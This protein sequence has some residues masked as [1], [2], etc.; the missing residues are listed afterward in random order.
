[1]RFPISIYGFCGA[2]LKRN[3]KRGNQ[4]ENCGDKFRVKG[5]GGVNM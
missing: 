4:L 2:K 3:D 1:M 5:M